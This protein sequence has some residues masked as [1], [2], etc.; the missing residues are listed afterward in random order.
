VRRD[1]KGMWGKSKN[2]LV[3][4]ILAGLLTGAWLFFA[5]Y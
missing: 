5:G 3:L 2:E 1:K 4:T